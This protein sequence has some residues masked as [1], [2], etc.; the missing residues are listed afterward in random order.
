MP[1]ERDNVL[2]VSIDSIVF[3]T[4]SRFFCKNDI[5]TFD[6]MNTTSTLNVTKQYCIELNL[7][8]KKLA[9]TYS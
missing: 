6:K 4:I 9:H 8:P 7:S 2:D 3:Y 1:L 5:A